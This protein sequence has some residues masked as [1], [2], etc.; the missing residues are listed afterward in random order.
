MASS[1]SGP[2]V[3][4]ASWTRRPCNTCF[5]VASSHSL[6]V[7]MNEILEGHERSTGPILIRFMKFLKKNTNH[8][9]EAYLF[10]GLHKWARLGERLG[11]F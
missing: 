11:P 9:H 3:V 2:A 10:Y 5:V 4:E 8:C 6:S 7:H 1:I